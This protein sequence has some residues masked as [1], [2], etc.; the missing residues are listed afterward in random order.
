MYKFKIIYQKGGAAA[1]IETKSI[2]EKVKDIT[3]IISKN[4][5]KFR[6]LKK[7]EN[8][9]TDEIK[10]KLKILQE[11]IKSLEE[12]SSS[13]K[14]NFNKNIEEKNIML[15][16][17]EEEII[18]LNK[19]IEEKKIMLKKLQEEI[20]EINKTN[21]TSEVD[22]KLLKLKEEEEALISELDKENQDDKDV[23]DGEKQIT[24]LIKKELT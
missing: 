11:N 5:S 1:T 20:T 16:K 14:N 15:K 17:L 18:N 12:E 2:D 21:N 24:E 22:K 8:K 6:E 19:T 9:Q 23:N 13:I 7:E 10:K 4:V 3:E